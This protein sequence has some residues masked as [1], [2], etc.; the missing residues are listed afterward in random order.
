MSTSTQ[1]TCR[2]HLKVSLLTSNLTKTDG[3]VYTLRTVC[4][5][6]LWRTQANKPSVQIGYNW[7]P[8]LLHWDLYYLWW[9]TTDLACRMEM[10]IYSCHWFKWCTWNDYYSH[11]SL[12]R[13]F[14]KG[15][16]GNVF[17]GTP[18]KVRTIKTMFLYHTIYLY[19]P[20]YL[21]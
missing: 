10:I 9:H 5:F 16:Q 14:R 21:L 8:I 18:G 1:R 2:N 7:S 12:L 15:I 11:L 4:C 19:L 13:F 20:M 17:H 3:A 6:A